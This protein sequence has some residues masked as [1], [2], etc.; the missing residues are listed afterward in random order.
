MRQ[1]APGVHVAERPLRFLGLEIGARMTVLELDDG[2]L[3]HSPI[4]VEPEVLAPLG[5]A[6]FALAPNKLHHLFVD[7]W[8]EA[9]V[10]TWAADGLAA[11]KPHV[12]FAGVPR[13]GTHPFGPGVEVV[14]LECFPFTNEVVLFHERSKTLVVTDLVFNIP[15]SAPWPTRAAMWC[16]C[17]YPG[18]ETSLLERVGMKRDLARREISA[19]LAF[20]FERIVLSHG[21]LVE[22]DAKARFAHAYRWLGPLGG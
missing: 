20:D 4:D 2:L 17:C 5:E 11:K 1:I 8:A 15:T 6:R 14:A 10:E 19:L 3:L 12:P 9:G 22:H 7:R 13:T 16:A 21:E 18:V